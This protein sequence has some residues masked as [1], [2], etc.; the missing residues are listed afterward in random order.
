MKSFVIKSSVM[1]SGS[2]RF[3]EEVWRFD[4]VAAPLPPGACDELDFAAL[5]PRLAAEAQGPY[6]LLRRTSGG[7]P[8]YG[9]GCNVA[10]RH[11]A[12]CKLYL[13]HLR[14]P[15]R[16]VVGPTP[17]LDKVSLHGHTERDG[18]GDVMSV[19]QWVG[20]SGHEW[21]PLPSTT[22]RCDAYVNDFGEGGPGLY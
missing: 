11:A 7:Q 18:G 12:N 8:V 17:G 21:E 10:A 5:P 15:S 4:P 3:E 1:K 14:G 19:P 9:K 2:W 13:F 22:L 16:W 20:W 6:R